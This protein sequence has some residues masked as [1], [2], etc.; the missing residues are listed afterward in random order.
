[1][2]R[3]LRPVLFRFPPEAAHTYTLQALALASQTPGGLAALRAYFIRRAGGRAAMSLP[4]HVAGLSFANPVGIAA[5]YDKN[6]LAVLGLGALGCGH[7]EVGTLTNLPQLGNPQ[8]RVFRLPEDQA[9]INRMGFPNSG[10]DVALPRLQAVRKH[11]VRPLIGVN[12]GKGKETPLERA[13]DDYCALLQKTH[14][15]ADYLV[16]NISSPNTQGLRQLQTRAFLAELLQ[17]LLAQRANL[18][19]QLPLF[20]K[21]APDLTWAEL[22]DILAVVQSAGCSGLIATNTTLARP[23]TLQNPQAIESGGLSGHPLT[24]RSTE[25][26]RYLYRQTRGTLPIIGVGGIITPADAVAKLCSGASLV[27][28]YTGLIYTGPGLVAAILQAV[29]QTLQRHGLADVA[30]LVGSQSGL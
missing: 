28:V 22:D 6:A 1:M 29:H 17:P 24:E 5:G 7:V 14:A 23:S 25:V 2:Y 27:Q 21:I 20:V 16:V 18:C 3:Y 13:S 26:I 12:I 15:V 10:V 11:A 9:V 19:P 30:A 4:V 8:P